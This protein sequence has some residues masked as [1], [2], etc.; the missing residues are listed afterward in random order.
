MDFYVN[1][2]TNNIKY[3]FNP[4]SRPQTSDTLATMN[5][6]VIR[7]AYGPKRMQAPIHFVIDAIISRLGGRSTLV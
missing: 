1:N 7:G 6:L 3:K 2:N 4:D 5:I